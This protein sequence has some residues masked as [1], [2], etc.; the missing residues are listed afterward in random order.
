MPVEESLGVSIDIRISM[1]QASI[2]C[3]ARKIYLC[4]SYHCPPLAVPDAD[5]LSVTGVSPTSS[6]IALTW[7][8]PLERCQNGDITGYQIHYTN[9]PSLPMDSWLKQ[10]DS[11]TTT[12]ST[13]QELEIF[14]DYS[15]CIAARTVIE[16]YG[17]C[18]PLTVIRTLNESKCVPHVNITSYLYPTLSC[19]CPYT[20]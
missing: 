9:Q 18:S 13:L 16:G 2:S 4:M 3:G 14:S 20:S 12:T 11:G 7:E 6:S 1:V 15:I 8:P 17:P 10:T 5:P 19:I